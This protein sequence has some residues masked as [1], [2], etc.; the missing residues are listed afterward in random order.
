MALR[1]LINAFQDKGHDWPEAGVQVNGDSGNDVELFEVPRVNGCIVSNAHPELRKF[2]EE[3]SDDP[4]IFQATKPCAGGIM[5]AMR[6]FGTL[7]QLS[8]GQPPAL[9]VL[10]SLGDALQMLGQFLSATVRN[11][12]GAR[13]CDVQLDPQGLPQQLSAVVSPGGLH[14]SLSDGTMQVATSTSDSV[15]ALPTWLDVL[16]VMC[17]V[18]TPASTSGIVT[19]EFLVH[20]LGDSGCRDVAAALRCKAVLAVGAGGEVKLTSA[21]CSAGSAEVI[22]P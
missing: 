13:A 22:L 7:E 3:H 11:A 9:A 4:R 1:F 12:C 6:H 8:K 2:A 19:A 17:D 10:R 16:E 20:V 15:V 14:L 21:A 18:T 5:E